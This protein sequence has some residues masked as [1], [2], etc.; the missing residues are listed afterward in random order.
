M[1]LSRD[2][3]MGW[4]DVFLVYLNTAH[5]RRYPVKE[6]M[7]YIWLFFIHKVKGKMAIAQAV[8]SCVAACAALLIRVSIPLASL[9]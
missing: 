6:Y 2:S 5:A 8:C 3:M 7:R 9:Y 1:D 4:H